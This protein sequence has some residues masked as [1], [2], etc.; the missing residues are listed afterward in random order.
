MLNRTPKDMIKQVAVGTKTDE[1][2]LAEGVVYVADRRALPTAERI[3]P[4]YWVCLHPT[5]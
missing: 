2:E 1:K 5:H 3:L 4:L